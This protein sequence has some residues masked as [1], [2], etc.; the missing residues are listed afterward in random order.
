ML[1]TSSR[2]NCKHAAEIDDLD[3]LGKEVCRHVAA[4]A[5]AVQNFVE[6]ALAAGD[7]LVRAKTQIKHGSWGD[8][9]KKFCGLNER[10][11]QRYMRIAEHRAELNP[12]HVSDLSMSAALKL[13]AKPKSTNSSPTKNAKVAA[14]F[15]PLDWWTNASHKERFHFLDGVGLKPLLAAIPPAWRQEAEREIG[16]VSSRATT[17]LKLA[18]STNNE[19]EAI[20]ALRD[21]NRVLAAGRYDLHD[22]E[23]HLNNHRRLCRAA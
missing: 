4:G 19:G 13:I 2:A 21:V 10:T 8:W 17:L 7:A 1:D 18:L 20:A 6:H 22:L 15:D 3:A 5:N 23:L 9:L 14:S 12:T 16:P 11:A